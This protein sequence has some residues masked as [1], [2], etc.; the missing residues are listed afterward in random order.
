MRI[1]EQSVVLDLD[2][3][4]VACAAGFQIGDAITTINGNTISQASALPGRTWLRCGVLCP[5]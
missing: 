4:G 5:W 3:R 2:P 1:D